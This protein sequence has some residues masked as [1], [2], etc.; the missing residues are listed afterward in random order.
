MQLP[1]LKIGF[2]A[3][4]FNFQLLTDKNTHSSLETLASEFFGQPTTIE[5]IKLSASQPAAP[6][7]AE[8]QQRQQLSRQEQ[9]RV[10]AT[11]HPMVQAATRIFDGE[12]E[13]IRPIDKGFT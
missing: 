1:R 10:N 4:S 13:E 6:S 9:L 8:E 7:L 11:E 12:V 2:P 3:G 5:I